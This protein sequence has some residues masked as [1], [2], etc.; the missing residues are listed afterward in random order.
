VRQHDILEGPPEA[1][2]F[3]VVHA[4]AVIEW[5][6]DRP[7]ALSN[8][9]AALKPGGLLLIEDVDIE[10]SYF[11][12]PPNELRRIALE[13]IG[14]ISASIGADLTFGRQLRAHLDQFGLAA[15][16]SDVRMILQ[17]G[18]EPT[19]EFQRL[20]LE[21]LGPVMLQS[22]MVTPEQL[23]QIKLD[24]VDPAIYGYPPAMVAVW[25][26]RATTSG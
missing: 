8:M 5:V 25:G 11:G 15:M 9:V 1:E 12:Y 24:L 21:T 23:E 14:A 6:A 19:T 26:R 18:G 3:D 2:A 17:R 4:R 22:G 13:A 10:P 16:G 20:T 7:K